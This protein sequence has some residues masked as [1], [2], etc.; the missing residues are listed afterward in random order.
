MPFHLLSSGLGNDATSLLPE[1]QIH[2]DARGGGTYT[3]SLSGGVLPSRGKKSMWD[4][5]ILWDGQ[6]ATVASLE[7]NLE[8]ITQSLCV[9]FFIFK[10][11]T[12]SVCIGLFHTH[13]AIS[14]AV[15]LLGKIPWRRKWQPTPVFLPG[16]FHGQRGLAGYSPW[17]RTQ[18]DTVE[19]AGT[20]TSSHRS[21]WPQMR[22]WSRFSL[23]CMI[24]PQSHPQLSCNTGGT[25]L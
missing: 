25:Y 3:P 23:S 11:G 6:S 13:W 15:T 16:R 5:G 7:Y 19:R 14:L 4:G 24:Q 10:M 20:C 9:H 12:P 2:M 17:G 8:H 1:S 18:L 22:H 21:P